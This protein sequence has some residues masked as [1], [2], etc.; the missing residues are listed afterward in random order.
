MRLLKRDNAGGVCFT[1][2]LP[3]SELP[4]YRYAI[5]SHT[6]GRD[7]EEVTYK[8]ILSGTGTSKSG[9]GSA[10]VRFCIQQTRQDGLDY[11]WIDTC[12]IDKKNFVEL[13]R[14]LRSMFRWYSNAER[15]YVFISDVPQNDQSEELGTDWEQ[16]FRF[17]KWFKRGW[18]L[19][20][21]IAPTVVEFFSKHGTRLGT[22]ASLEQQINQITRIPVTAIRGRALANFT[23][24]ERRQWQE[25]RETREPEDLVYSL[26]GLLDVSMPVL[27]GE[28][29]RKAWERLE[30]AIIIAR[31]GTRMMQA[32]FRS[33][34]V[35]CTDNI[36]RDSAR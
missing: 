18:T 4:S 2:D 11:F 12:C 8:D 28:G 1:E 14:S 20:E 26:L 21:L 27:Y 22:K 3:E 29:R 36:C 10:K 13:D 31:K 19:Q 5:L 6:W 9:I 16:V 17:S 23:V 24:Q 34:T 25:G 30:S 33:R 15:C 7:E 32:L 35:R